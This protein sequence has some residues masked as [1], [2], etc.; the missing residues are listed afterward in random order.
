MFGRIQERIKAKNGSDD[1]HI[2][3]L[4]DHGFG[5]Y[6]YQANLNRW[7]INRGYLSEG[8]GDK[9]GDLNTVNW[10]QSK[11]YAVGLNSLYLNLEDRESGGCVTLDEQDSLV[12]KLKDDLSHW[13]G[14]DGQTVIQKVLTQEEAFQGPYTQYAPD[15]VIGY[16]PKYRAS[17]RTGL[18]QWNHN[19]IEDNQDHWGADH[20]F[21]SAAVPGVLFSNKGLGNFSSPSYTDIPALAIGKSIRQKNKDFIPPTYSDEDQDAIDERLKGLGY[22]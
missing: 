10:S 9:S 16:R 19:E 21:D 12:Q 18:G 8:N 15:L 1:I 5:E 22:L 4:S 2:M 13:I 11:A 17:A 14:P 20:C 3:M 7:L 6:A